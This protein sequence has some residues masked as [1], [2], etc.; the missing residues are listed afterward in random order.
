MKRKIGV[1]MKPLE[2]EQ[3]MLDTKTEDTVIMNDDQIVVYLANIGRDDLINE[4]LELLDGLDYMSWIPYANDFLSDNGI[5]LHVVEVKITA[6][7]GM[8]T[9]TFER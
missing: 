8:L 2:V 4:W 7:K 9:W 6:G 5:E 3:E 1:D